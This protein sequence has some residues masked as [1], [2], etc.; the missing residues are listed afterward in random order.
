M[1]TKLL[2][3]KQT[4]ENLLKYLEQYNNGEINYQVNELKKALEIIQSSANYTSK[5]KE[6]SDIQKNIYP[7][8][9]GLS[10]FYV[11]RSDEDERI[12]INKP[13]SELGDTLWNLLK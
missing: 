12:A 3:I 9:G 5:I 2:E 1:E 8:R 11:W 13:I 6:I 10:D 4:I 7:T